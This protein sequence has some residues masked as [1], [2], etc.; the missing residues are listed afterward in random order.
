ML[1]QW[2]VIITSKGR[3]RGSV[4]SIIME[5]QLF[6]DLCLGAAVFQSHDRSSQS[7][8]RPPG[9]PIQFYGILGNLRNAGGLEK[10]LDPPK[11][12]QLLMGCHFRLDR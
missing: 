7:L 12:D 3:L 1:N 2:L 8:V 9:I 11:W 5:R 6:P 4:V 10:D